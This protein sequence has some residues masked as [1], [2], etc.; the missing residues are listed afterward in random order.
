[1]ET[2]FQP[3]HACRFNSL[4]HA[5][6][7]PNQDAHQRGSF[8][9]VELGTSDQAGAKRFYSNLFAW[10][11]N[12]VP[13]GPDNFY[14]LFQLR[15]RDVAAAYTLF[16]DQKERGIPPHWMLYVAVENVDS[17]AEKAADLGGKILSPPFDVFDLGRMTVIQD[18]TGGVFAT[19]QAK[20][21]HGIGVASEE[22]A[23]CWADLTTTDPKKAVNFYSQLFG[24]ETEVS[25]NDPSGYLHILNKGSYIGGI[26]PVREG[27]PPP[28]WLIYYQVSGIETVLERAT[29]NGATTYQPPFSV[30]ETGQIAVLADPQGAVFALFEPL[31]K[32]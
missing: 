28:H 14:T 23:F 26:P 30:P 17:T 15:G 22:G 12:D 25:K 19:W 1:M 7:M 2:L 32:G 20:R 5:S 16:P 11:V 9:W 10:T 18:P 3:L 31:A 6:L 21:H 29:S 13:I 24:W 27:Q 8:C 4:G